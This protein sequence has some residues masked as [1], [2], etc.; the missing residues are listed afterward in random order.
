[1]TPGANGVNSPL[2]TIK[3]T[4][5]HLIR[6]VFCASNIKYIWF[7][8]EIIMWSCTFFFH[9]LYKV[10]LTDSSRL[11]GLLSIFKWKCLCYKIAVGEIL[12]VDLK[13]NPN[14]YWNQK[15]QG[16]LNNPL[17]SWK[18]CDFFFKFIKNSG[19]FFGST[20]HDQQVWLRLSTEGGGG[21][22]CFT[23]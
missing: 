11:I 18:M 23:C 5:W 9:Q 10:L 8:N 1:M 4:N 14:L 2:K 19:N 13:N 17:H 12:W 7:H 16:G 3:T 15:V 6:W 22:S 20:K 21:A